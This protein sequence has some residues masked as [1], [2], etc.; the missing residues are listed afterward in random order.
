MAGEVNAKGLEAQ[1]QFNILKT[2]I[3]QLGQ[4][5]YEISRLD[6]AAVANDF[7][8]VV[9]T[10]GPMLTN[11]ATCAVL[12]ADAIPNISVGMATTVGGV[13]TCPETVAAAGGACWILPGGIAISGKGAIEGAIASIPCSYAIDNANKIQEY[14]NNISKFIKS[15]IELAKRVNNSIQKL[16]TASEALV[17]LAGQL[18][19]NA[20]PRLLRIQQSLDRSVDAINNA[21]TILSTEVSPRVEKFSGSVLQQ[22]NDNTAALANC[23][24]RLKAL[25]FKLGERTFQAM[26]ELSEALVFLVDGGKIITNLYNQS[27]A[28]INSAGQ[29]ISNNWGSIDSTF[30]NL[31]RRAFGIDYPTV[32]LFIT[33]LY[34]GRLATNL[35]EV[36][37]IINEVGAIP[38]RIT[39]LIVNAVVQGKRAFLNL[40]G[41]KRTARGK[42]DIAGSKAQSALNTYKS[43]SAPPLLQSFQAISIAPLPSFTSTLGYQRAVKAPIQYPVIQQRQQLPV[44]QRR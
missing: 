32:N 3:E 22:I 9:T 29:Y 40:D 15:A 43:L 6:I 4:E 38:G 21:Y 7:I 2:A 23:Y 26:A 35:T 13:A 1:R 33:I 12:L 25:M 17:K 18:S 8:N 34:L 41:D 11:C 20:Q 16:K 14:V 36:G 27:R 19:V 30:K 10:V 28:G 31:Y 44:P 37:N 5:A 42:F 24:N 39:N